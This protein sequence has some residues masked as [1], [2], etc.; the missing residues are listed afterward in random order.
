MKPYNLWIK[1][2]IDF[3]KQSRHWSEDLERDD[4]REE[5]KKLNK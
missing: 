2:T 3:I 5:S 1:K 4:I